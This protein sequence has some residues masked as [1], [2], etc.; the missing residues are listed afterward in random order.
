MEGEVENYKLMP[1]ELTPARR[2]VRAES[3]VSQ[4]PIA[5]SMI[6]NYAGHRTH[7]LSIKFGQSWLSIIVEDK[8]RVDH[9]EQ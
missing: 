3:A 4:C 8:C 5:V 2:S 6:T 9:D 7:K 1:D